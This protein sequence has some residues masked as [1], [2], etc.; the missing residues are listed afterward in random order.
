MV[1]PMRAPSLIG[2]AQDQLA[3][4]LKRR[5][6]LQ[7]TRVGVGWPDGGPRAPEDVWIDGTVPDWT[8]EWDT[9]GIAGVA[10]K[11]E[12]FD[13]VV[14][15]MATR[16]VPTFVEIRD[17]VLELFAELQFVLDNDW[18]LAGVVLQSALTKCSLA[19]GYMT[20]GARQCLLE[21]TVHVETYLTG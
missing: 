5:P 12:A 1:D 20:D 8:M 10:P 4:L 21:V 14:N 19:E 17:V 11:D 7:E 2:V 9:T 16:N 15:F 18:Q 13:L 6:R 3:V